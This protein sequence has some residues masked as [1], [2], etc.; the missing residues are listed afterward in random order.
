LPALSGS[1]CLF[2][3]SKKQLFLIF[4]EKNI[5]LRI[6]PSFIAFCTVL[7]LIQNYASAMKLRKQQQKRS[8]KLFL[9]TLY[10]YFDANNCLHHFSE[11]GGKMLSHGRPGKTTRFFACFLMYI[12]L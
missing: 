5:F 2:K 9:V 12:N 8:N 4:F 3:K 6:L 11:N 1:P 7:K 10:E